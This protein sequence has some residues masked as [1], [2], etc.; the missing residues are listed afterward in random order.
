MAPKTPNCP[1]TDSGDIKGEKIKNHTAQ[2]FESTTVEVTKQINMVLGKFKEVTKQ[3]TI[4]MKQTITKSTEHTK[5]QKTKK[6]SRAK[7]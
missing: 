2:I 6:T 3:I 1:K 7:T 4:L 5:K